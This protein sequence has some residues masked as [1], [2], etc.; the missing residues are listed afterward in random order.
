MLVI[1]LITTPIPDDELLGDDQEEENNLLCYALMFNCVHCGAPHNI[2]PGTK[3]LVCS[4]C[5]TVLFFR[6]DV[7]Q[8]DWVKWWVLPFP[9]MFAIGKKYYV[10]LDNT[11]LHTI[12][13]KN[14]RYYN[15]QEWAKI[16]QQNT[17]KLLMELYVY[18]HCRLVND[19]GF[20]EQRFVRPLSVDA[21]IIIPKQ[22]DLLL[23]ED[24]WQITMY[25]VSS[26]TEVWSNHAVQKNSTLLDWMFVQD[27]G[28]A[29]LEWWEWQLL[30]AFDTSK[31]ITYYRLE[32]NKT[33]R[34]I[35]YYNTTKLVADSI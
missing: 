10:V 20:W 27:S 3:Q 21:Q 2:L 23:E 26:I 32:N 4:Y 1:V 34:I 29:Q 18:G 14:I 17:N 11:S 5:K 16:W 13:N 33:S 22:K 19:G 7:L 15:E 8:T 35:D 12:A 6:H 30:F 31:H 25:A 28:T 24:E 9:T